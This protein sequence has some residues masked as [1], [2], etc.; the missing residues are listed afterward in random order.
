MEA[1]SYVD[2]T[3]YAYDE[4]VTFWDHFWED[5]NRTLLPD[6]GDHIHHRQGG[7]NAHN[8]AA[9]VFS[10]ANWWLLWILASSVVLLCRVCQLR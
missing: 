7:D 3:I 1:E 8:Y 10:P 5:H 4:N 9:L 6:N 2:S